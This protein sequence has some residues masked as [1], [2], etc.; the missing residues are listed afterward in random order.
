M[1]HTYKRVRFT[2]ALLL[3]GLG[4]LSSIT[5]AHAASATTNDSQI[6][7]ASFFAQAPAFS[8]PV[9][10]SD[11]S[12]I[13]YMT[14][15]KGKSLLVIRTLN[16]G[17]MSALPMASN[18]TIKWHRWASNDILLVG[19]GFSN[20][21]IE[22][23]GKIEET[24]LGSFN[25]SKGKFKWLDQKMMT[26]ARMNSRIKADEG[27]S[28]FQDQIIDFLPND[29]DFVLQAIDSDID[30]DYE[31]R[32]LNIRTGKY[33]QAQDDMR[34]IQNWMTDRDHNPRFNWGVSNVTG[35]QALYKSARTQQ[36]VNT[37]D[38]EWFQ[39]GF[40]ILSFT[41][42]PEIAYV[43]GPSEHGKKGVFTMNTET[44][45]IVDTLFVNPEVDF[46]SLTFS[47][48][49]GNDSAANQG[50]IS[51][52]VYDDG[53]PQKQYISKYSR[54][55]QEIVDQSLPDT[56]NNIVSEARKAKRYVIH[57]TT[58]NSPGIYYM[59][60]LNTGSL[61]ALSE[62]MP[63][64][65]PA[66]LSPVEKVSIPTRDGTVITGYLTIPSGK[67]AENL[68][69][70]IMPHAD[71]HGRDYKEF[72]VWAQFIA[73]R[74][75]LV[76]QPNFRGSSGYGAEFQAAGYNQWG[77]LMQQ[78]ITDATKWLISSGKANPKKICMVG[79]S[80]GGYAAMMGAAQNPNMYKC[81]ASI[82]GI[83]D[84]DAHKQYVK[85]NR[86]GGYALVDK[87]GLQGANV[88]QV[89]PLHNADK[90]TAPALII[91]AKDDATV[92][93]NQSKAMYSKL[94]KNAGTELVMLKNGAHTLTN[95]KA[96]LKV[97]KSLDAFLAQNL[98]N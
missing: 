43:S 52:I 50:V 62:K 81:V 80:F 65:D 78:D 17:K 38:V 45:K 72:N 23:K 64:L 57:A 69:V 33:S 60:D 47:Q 87:M 15:A 37:T 86:K 7:P 94:K 93:S 3:A 36:W 44:G 89:S 12:K 53:E 22:Y 34:G 27:L 98:S 14:A 96:R 83:L 77:G 97:F 90:I 68:P 19:Y 42:N 63:G 67:K 58:A 1:L 26:D 24:R 75:Y 76:L 20:N 51:S 21:R 9:L 29:P 41:K 73:N 56:V 18:A 11:G 82:N 28:Q 2:A 35:R 95:A 6:I 74:G 4:G 59:L 49:T 79:S 66:L 70:V 5:A 55:I 71:P 85:F 39:K 8:S 31:I 13:A 40:R 25:T 88:K 92:I 16:D 91:A 32:K 54:K 48:A 10:S 84:L 30:G 61:D 46:T